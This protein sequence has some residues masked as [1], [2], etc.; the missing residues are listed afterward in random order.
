MTVGQCVNPYFFLLQQHD[1]RQ[2]DVLFFFLMETKHWHFLGFTI[3]FKNSGWP[4]VTSQAMIFSLAKFSFCFVRCVCNLSSSL[5]S[6]EVIDLETVLLN[7]LSG[8]VWICISTWDLLG[9]G[10][11]CACFWPWVSIITYSLVACILRGE[12]ISQLWWDIRS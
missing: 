3:F 8:D 6:G 7:V 2:F 5:L 11:L 4:P 10:V 12:L 9:F 1:M